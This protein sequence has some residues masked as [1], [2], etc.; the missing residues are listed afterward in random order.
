MNLNFRTAKTEDIPILNSI[1]VQSKG[2][3]GYPESW[4]E[5]WKDDLTIDT[6][7]LSA[8]NFL[9]AENENQ[10][11]GFSSIIEKPELYEITHLWILP[12]FIGKGNGKKLLEA[13]IETFVNKDLP[14]IVEADPN[15]EAFYKSQ[16]FETFDKVE[17][18]P[19]GRYLPVMRRSLRVGS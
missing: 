14:I 16:G 11:I 8:Q 1:S 19:S 18:F 3:W 7:M 4:M 2:H 15:A 17:S 9:I 6:K 12:T 13:T 5:Q 10:I